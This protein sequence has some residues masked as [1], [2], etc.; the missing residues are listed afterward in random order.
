MERSEEG[1]ETREHTA[2]SS[3]S[4]AA[5]RSPPPSFVLFENIIERLQ[6]S[7]THA[8]PDRF[9]FSS[10]LLLHLCSL[11]SSRLSCLLPLLSFAIQPFHLEL[12]RRDSSLSPAAAAAASFC[13][14]QREGLPPFFHSPVLLFCLLL[15]R[16]AKLGAS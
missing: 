8:R 11:H 6:K 9:S 16:C 7:G 13:L 3:N 15:D 5:I 12:K 14:C 4:I 1:N 2:A 10:S